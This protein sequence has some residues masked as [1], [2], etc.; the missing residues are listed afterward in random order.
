MKFLVDEALPDPSVIVILHDE[1]Q[2]RQNYEETLGRHP[3]RQFL[4]VH[5][6]GY[7][8]GFLGS[9]VYAAYRHTLLEF[10]TFANQLTSQ[11]Q[12]EVFRNIRVHCI[13]PQPARVESTGE[14][15]M[16]YLLNFGITEQHLLLLRRDRCDT[17]PSDYAVVQTP[18]ELATPHHLLG[19]AGWDDILQGGLPDI[20]WG[21]S[22]IAI[23]DLL[24][25]RTGMLIVFSRPAHACDIEE[26]SDE[27]GED[28]SLLQLSWAAHDH[29]HGRTIGANGFRQ[30]RPPGNGH[31][32]FDALVWVVEDEEIKVYH[33]T[34]N[35]FLDALC[36]GLS[37]S[38]DE[39][40]NG[41]RADFRFWCN[42]NQRG[43]PSDNMF[44]QDFCS[45]LQASAF[46]NPFVQ[47]YSASF[48]EACE[49]GGLHE[50]LSTMTHIA[51]VEPPEDVG[52]VPISL[53][54][55]IGPRSDPPHQ[56]ELSAEG[57]IDF[58]GVVDALAWLD[59][60]VTLPSYV[61]PPGVVWHESSTDWICLNWWVDEPIREIHFYTDGSKRS[62]GCGLA[63]ALFVLT[64]D[65]DWLFGGY[66]AMKIEQQGSYAAELSALVVTFKWLYDIG[67]LS[68]TLP[69]VAFVHFDSTSAGFRSTG[70]WEGH[71]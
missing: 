17:S 44:Q 51:H 16:H 58:S 64:M 19:L 69:D 8:G 45:H 36:E 62:A 63:T 42:K 67:R 65:G 26:A 52:N 12:D 43:H 25:M 32:T 5:T 39:T 37:D 7:H 27:G 2:F 60:H 56:L 40:S 6:H 20:S 38:W 3:P 15:E 35:P 28:L 14:V 13:L 59:S 57:G 47:A 4:S 11:W 23:D 33:Q 41:F 30:L 49:K 31:V 9:R 50:E 1:V 55:I 68:C 18:S 34:N 21:T 54:E 29:L 46:R 66:K 71:T 48:E 24:Q 22:A 53:S 10:E 61:D 70:H